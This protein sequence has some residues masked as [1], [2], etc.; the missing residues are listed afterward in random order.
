MN[1]KLLIIAVVLPI[2]LAVFIPLIPFRKRAHMEIYIEAVVILTSVLVFL[3]LFNRPEELVMLRFTEK[4]TLALKID[5]LSMVFAGLISV[6][7][8]IATLYSY[9]YMSTEEREQ[10]FFMFYTMTYGVT[11][12]IAFS[13]NIVTMYF[14][15]EMLTLVTIPLVIH[16]FTKEAVLATRKYIY[17]SIGGAAL[18]FMGMVFLIRC[19]DGSGFTPGGILNG[20]T[21]GVGM[22]LVLLLYVIAFLGFSIKAAMFPF[23]SWLPDAGVAPTPVT[24]L[25]H[26][27]AVVKAGGFAIIRLT[28]YC[29]GTEILRGTWAQKVV[30]VLAMFT[31]VFGCSMA[32]KETHMKRRLAFST[33]SNLS[34]IIFGAT[35][36]T[37]AGLLGALCHMVFHAVMKISAFF[38]SGSI[39][40]QSH[41]HYIYEM[42]GFGR[43]MPWVYGAFTVSALGLMGVPGGCGFI[44]KWY[45]AK[46]ALESGNYMAWAGVGCLLISALLTAIYMMAI[47]VRGFFPEKGFNEKSIENVKDPSWQMI[48]PLMLFSIAIIGFGIY[49]APL[50]DFLT[51]VV[52]GVF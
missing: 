19:G 36:M 25:L 15:Y 43:R 31:I 40:H 50:T 23:Y 52:N 18:G 35:I 33:V 9:E 37:P 38:C 28:Y 3:L 20:G 47:V 13:A 30:M 42:D 29:F 32:V 21:A 34:Y 27:V 48:L 22:D 7:W 44:S 39:I 41:K 46:A 49:S 51:K 1:E 14:F 45:L 8:P 26:A 6:L 24:A 5:G 10:P 2:I 4:V 11:L 17:F 16:I 12:G